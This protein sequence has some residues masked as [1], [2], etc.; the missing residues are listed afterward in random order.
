MFL[1]KK[2]AEI[3]GKN[4]T[5]L[6]NFLWIFSTDVFLLPE[7]KRTTQLRS[8]SCAAVHTFQH[9]FPG[10]HR[11]TTARVRSVGRRWWGVVMVNGHIQIAEA[12]KS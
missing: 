11:F 7:T 3:V 2:S 4:S 8:S 12:K 10:Y 5:H 9:N 1:R 6:H